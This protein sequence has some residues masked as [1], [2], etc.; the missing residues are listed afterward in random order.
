MQI[1]MA[2][3]SFVRIIIYMSMKNANILQFGE[4]SKYGELF[5]SKN[6]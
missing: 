4:K 6:K 1:F 3:Y 2:N 5:I